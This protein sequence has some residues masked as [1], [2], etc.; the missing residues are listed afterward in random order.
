MIQRLL[1]LFLLFKS[2]LSFGLDKAPE[3]RR[4]CM[5]NNTSMATIFWQKTIDNC[6]SFNR[7]NIY[8]QQNNSGWVLFKKETNINV[9]SADFFVADKNSTWTFKIVAYTGCNGI[10][11]F[12]SNTLAIDQTPPENMG[13]DSLSFERSS[14][15]LLVGWKSNPSK[16]TKGYRLYTYNNS[17][18]SKIIDTSSTEALLKTFDK[19]NPSEL[20]I[21]SFDSCNLFTP[22]SGSQKAVYL[23]G[24]IDTCAKTISLS[25]NL[26]MGWPA[27]KQY[28]VLD[29][30]NIGYRISKE[31]TLEETNLTINNITLGDNLCYYIRTEQIN[32]R[33]TSSSNTI[34]FATR[35]L[36]VPKFNYISNV[37]VDNNTAIK[38]SLLSDLD[39]DTDSILLEREVNGLNGYKPL[40]KY[41]ANE[42]STSFDQYDYSANF[43]SFYYSYRVK[44]IDKCLNQSSISNIGRSIYLTNPFVLKNIWHFTWNTYSGWEKGIETQEIETSDNRFTWNIFKTESP[45]V[46]T[47][48]YSE[49]SLTSDSLCFRVINK[50][51]LNN[52]NTSSTSISN[53]QCIYS[54]K[55][56]Y[57]PGTINPNSHNNTFRIYG[58]GLDKTRA[59]MEIFNRWGEKI[60]ET[61][62]LETGWDTKLNGELADMGSYI[63]KSTF[64]DLRNKY[65]IKTGTIFIIR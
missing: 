9:I 37:T 59:K 22:I 49:E 56:F 25:W 20:S 33:I 12:A 65:Y 36:K 30:N 6:S 10:D 26:Y 35:K 5:D 42:I 16:D 60:F 48:K 41:K 57:F 52:N 31:L 2:A 24:K 14:Q 15:K 62:D 47:L 46:E 8:Y 40:F 39:A 4:V 29:L 3:I 55:D 7:F 44:T 13:I 32:S 11:S 64:Y 34:C 28:L 43:N 50:E 21:A 17:V 1:I 58:I 23:N 18:N 45:N 38:I 54:I 51:E 27:S 61:T 53:I 19:S 63:Y